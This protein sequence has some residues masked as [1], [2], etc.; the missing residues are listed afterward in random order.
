MSWLKKKTGPPATELASAEKLKE[1]IEGNEVAVVGF[2]KEKDS[3]NAKIFLEAASDIDDIP[4]GMAYG[5]DSLKA[6]E[7][8]K[9]GAV[10]IFKKVLHYIVQR[11]TKPLLWF[12]LFTK[13]L[14]EGMQNC[15]S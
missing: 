6:Y 1:F 10:V 7:Q 9:F 15:G 2:F 5:E 4:F 8:D 13:D 14:L 3:D 11:N 12:V